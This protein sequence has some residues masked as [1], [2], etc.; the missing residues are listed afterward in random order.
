MFYSIYKNNLKLIRELYVKSKNKIHRRIHKHSM[1][2]F[3]EF[4]GDSDPIARGA[5]AKAKEQI[6]KNPIK[7]ECSCT[8]KEKSVE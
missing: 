5:K 8:R 7:L 6:N 4:Y 1:V 2:R 3:I